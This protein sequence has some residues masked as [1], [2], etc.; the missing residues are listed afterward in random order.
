M[1]LLIAWCANV[2]SEGNIASVYSP[3]GGEIPSTDGGYTVI[4]IPTADLDTLGF[5]SPAQFMNENSWNGSAW[6]NRGAKPGDWYE[7]TGSWTV[8]SSAIQEE[9]RRQRTI[10]LYQSDWTQAT[11][12]P[13]TDQKKA[14]WRTYRQSLRDIM[15]NLPSDLDDPENASWPTEPS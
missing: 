5:I 6:V 9:V 14:E 10:K 13:L 2:D 15:A 3:P 11:D 4:Q 1:S 7:W 12:S 8:A